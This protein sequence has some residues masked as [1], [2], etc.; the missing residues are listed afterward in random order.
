MTQR[1]EFSARR[2]RLLVV[3]AVVGAI[4]GFLG[5]A[6]ADEASDARAGKDLARQV[7][8]P[9]HAMPSQAPASQSPDLKA[10]SFLE[11]ARGSKAAPDQLWTFLKTAHN[12]IA[13]PGNMPRQELTEQQIRMLYAYIA[14]LR[15][16][17]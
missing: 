12:S 4:F 1:D 11:I 3:F 15:A 2:A 14:T 16:P 13:H 9:C 7:C 10:R 8:S 5:L 17:Q 6:N